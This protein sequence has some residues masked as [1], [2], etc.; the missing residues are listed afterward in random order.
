MRDLFELTTPAIRCQNYEY[1]DI[2][3]W[4]AEDDLPFLV[5]GC[6]AHPFPVSLHV[7]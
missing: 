1:E 4:V 3:D 2:E 6:A 7:I 5:V